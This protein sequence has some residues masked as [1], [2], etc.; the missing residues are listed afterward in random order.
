[1]AEEIKGLSNLSTDELDILFTS[2]AE[3]YSPIEINEKVYIIPQAVNDLIDSLY[4]QLELT[5]DGSFIEG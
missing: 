4:N 1:M 5:K 3:S 2:L